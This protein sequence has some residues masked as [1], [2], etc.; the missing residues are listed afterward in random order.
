MIGKALLFPGNWGRVDALKKSARPALR[1][2]GGCIPMLLIACLIEGFISPRTDVGP[3]LKFSISI[4]TAVLMLL[5]F[6]APR[7]DSRANSRN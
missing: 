4:G 5:Y 1:M 3:E 6:L 7:S 2:F